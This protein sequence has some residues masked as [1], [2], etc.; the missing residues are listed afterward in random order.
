MLH[1]SGF[2]MELRYFPEQLD[3]FWSMLKSC[4]NVQEPF[5]SKMEMLKRLWDCWRR[6]NIDHFCKFSRNQTVR[7]CF[8]AHA[9]DLDLAESVL[10]T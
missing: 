7:S 2:L 1:R 3:H 4:V 9:N 10:P 6:V 8:S 5:P